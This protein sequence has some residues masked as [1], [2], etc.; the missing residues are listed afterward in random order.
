MDS[1]AEQESPNRALTA[2]LHSLAHD[3]AQPLTTI[4]C[5]LELVSQRKP[6]VPTP[7]A[8]ELRSPSLQIDRAIAIS[9]GIS[10]LTR[11]VAAAKDPNI[12]LDA[13]LDEI[14]DN[15]G[16]LAHTGF[17]TFDRHDTARI[18]IASNAALRQGLIIVITKVA[19]QS[20]SPIKI[21]VAAD[22]GES[23]AYLD[24]SWRPNDSARIPPQTAEAIFAGDR[25]FLRELLQEAGADL[26]ECGNVAAL[27]ISVPAAFTNSPAAG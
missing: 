24:F 18:E 12:V 14:F 23:G 19:G 15:F 8:G 3:L 11:E 21:T 9:K 22:I 20:T 5:F 7:G 16:V 27:S 10:A 6:G 25:D 1:T 13:L 4:H 2:L 17:L 26:A